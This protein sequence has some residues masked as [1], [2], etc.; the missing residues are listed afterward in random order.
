MIGQKLHDL[1]DVLSVSHL[2]LLDFRCAK[3][4]DKRLVLLKFIMH[5]KGI[6][7]ID[8][9][10]FLD[11]EILKL[12]PNSK[13]AEHNLKIRR[14]VSYFIEQ[15]EKVILESYLEEDT[16][17]K[18]MLLARAVEKSANLSL[19][20]RY[21]NKTYTSSL[22]EADTFYQLMSLN[23]K[24]RMS[25]ASH[26]EKELEKTLHLNEE[27]LSVL[28]YTS[29]QKLAEY[30][31]NMSNIFLEKNSIISS[32]LVKVNLEINQLLQKDLPLIHQV[33]LNFSLAKLN[34]DQPIRDEY[35]QKA[36]DLLLLVEDKNNAYYLLERRI[37]FLELRLSFFTGKDLITL[38]SLADEILKT[39]VDYSI[40]NNNTLFYKILFTLLKGNHEAALT[41]L[42]DSHDHFKGT[43]TIMENF[44]KAVFF[45]KS[46][47]YKKAIQLLNPIMYASHYFFA[48][49]ARLLLIRIHLKRDNRLLCK[50][51]IDS[52]NK[53]LIQNNGNPLGMDSNKLILTILRKRMTN[54]DFLAIG[55][56]TM[57]VFHT[58]LIS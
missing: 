54:K 42:T 31:N 21:F 52:T 33:S 49:F 9:N 41:L 46:G 14:T 22:K 24:I 30:Y 35:F 53:F 43:G 1:L 6:S 19:V 8:L 58:Y 13:Q 47:D 25:Y 39:E 50:S 38:I 51:L 18:N 11:K 23:G 5:S 40:I 29:D 16:S 26:N 12:W 32:R 36:K 17:A 10:D 34:Y 57:S 27:F 56:Q 7:L 44:L 2:K 20:N 48:V 3:S 37:R 28:K 15:I 45:E 55:N 4:T